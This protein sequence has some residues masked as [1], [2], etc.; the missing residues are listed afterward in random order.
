MEKLI[1]SAIK[2]SQSE[3]TMFESISSARR[4]PVL[5][6]PID[7]E[8]SSWSN[9]STYEK[10]SLQKVFRFTNVK[11]VRYFVDEILKESDRIFH[12]PKLVIEGLTVEVELCTHDIN[13]VSALDV[14]LSKFADE[15][16]GEI[17]IVLSV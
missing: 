8:Q 17:S 6:M 9:V 5:E 4:N 7:P 15:V 3:S 2:R 10:N 1:L 13:D 14:Q 11:H 12:H 16:F